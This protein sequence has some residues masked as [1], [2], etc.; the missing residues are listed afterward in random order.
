MCNARILVQGK[1]ALS[2]LAGIINSGLVIHPPRQSMSK[3][4]RWKSAKEFEIELRE[5]LLG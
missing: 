1:S 2:Y 4:P 3:L 5:P